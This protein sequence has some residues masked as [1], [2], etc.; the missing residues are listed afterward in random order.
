[1]WPLIHQ[2]M[3][4]SSVVAIDVGKWAHR[5]ASARWERQTS[6]KIVPWTKQTWTKHHNTI[7]LF[8]NFHRNWRIYLILIWR[9]YIMKSNKLLNFL[10][11]E[12]VA[13][14]EKN[15]ERI[16][17]KKSVLT[18]F[19]WSTCPCK[20]FGRK[21]RNTDMFWKNI[22]KSRVGEKRRKGKSATPQ[23]TNKRLSRWARDMP[24]IFCLYV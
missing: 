2:L 20:T 12:G 17:N 10:S 13:N 5:L 9:I 15:K 6:F 1:M 16:E 7:I 23:D 21:W 4:S 19:C 8:R 24:G 18:S 14:E 3:D 11:S 22:N